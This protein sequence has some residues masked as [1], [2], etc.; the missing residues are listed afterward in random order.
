MTR[1]SEAY[2]YEIQH[3]DDADIVAYQRKSSDGVWRTISAWM[4]PTTGGRPLSAGQP[5]TGPRFFG[6]IVA[7]EP[8]LSGLPVRLTQP[9][10]LYSVQC[11]TCTEYCIGAFRLSKRIVLRIEVSAAIFSYEPSNGLHRRPPPFL[12]AL[13]L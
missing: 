9:T 10:T 6:G 11:F 8:R 2:R 13:E 12:G 3:S 5:L 4:I 1:H 7:G